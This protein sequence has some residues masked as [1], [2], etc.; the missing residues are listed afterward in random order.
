VVI[1]K[2]GVVKKVIVGFG[3]EPTAQELKQAVEAAMK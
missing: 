3:G 2:D 1:G